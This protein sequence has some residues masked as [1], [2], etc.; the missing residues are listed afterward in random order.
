MQQDF[1]KILNQMSRLVDDWTS[2]ESFCPARWETSATSETWAVLA[3]WAS[4]FDRKV[5]EMM[6]IAFQK[7]IMQIN[8][9]CAVD[10]MIR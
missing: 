8:K 5:G 4:K 9:N 6:R 10:E 7:C 2:G 3:H 1:H